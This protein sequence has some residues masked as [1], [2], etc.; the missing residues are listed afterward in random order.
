MIPKPSFHPKT[1]PCK[2]KPF[3]SVTV[4]IIAAS[5]HD[6]TTF[7]LI[8]AFKSKQSFYAS[9]VVVWKS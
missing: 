2:L 7:A 9:V 3:L 4:Q 1:H 6:V 8:S 5:C